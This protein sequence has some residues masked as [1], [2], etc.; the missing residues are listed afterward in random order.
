MHEP[1]VG[2]GDGRRPSSAYVDGRF[3]LVILVVSVLNVN[4][5]VLTLTLISFA[6]CDCSAI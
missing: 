1:G 4:D 2:G 3:T 6:L 5:L